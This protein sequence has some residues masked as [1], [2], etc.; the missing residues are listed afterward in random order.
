MSSI[1]QMWTDHALVCIGCDILGYLVDPSA[2]VVNL[3]HAGSPGLVTWD[4]SV[5]SNTPK[6][7]F[8][9]SIWE[10]QAA[11]SPPKPSNKSLLQ[12]ADFTSGWRSSGPRTAVV[13]M[14]LT[15][16]ISRVLCRWSNGI[17]I[18]DGTSFPARLFR[19]MRV[20]WYPLCC[21]YGIP[22]YIV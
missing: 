7:Y 2:C 14:A 12:L 9:S 20:G 4:L 1:L 5:S 19:T 22:H 18:L 6:T 15:R 13:C 11:V 17:Q 8:L 10:Q 21:W 3:S 16:P